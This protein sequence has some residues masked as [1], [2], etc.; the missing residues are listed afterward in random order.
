MGSKRLATVVCLALLTLV[1]CRDRSTV[2]DKQDKLCSAVADLDGSATQIAAV[3]PDAGGVARIK[4]LR[5]DMQA[6][7]KRLQ[8]AAKDA[9]AIRIDP[10]TQAYNKVLSSINGINDPTALAQ[11]QPRINQA[12]GEFSDAR[13]QLNQSAGC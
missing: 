2:Q 5:L 4:V 11:A 6:Q 9:Q 10:I 13:T 3:Q 8:D 12:V 1:G 7:Y